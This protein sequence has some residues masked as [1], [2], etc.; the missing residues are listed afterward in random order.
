MSM[1]RRLRRQRDRAYDLACFL[2]A[3][4]AEK[5]GRLARFRAALDAQEEEVERLTKQLQGAVPT[6]YEEGMK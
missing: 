2:Q 4:L 1:V 3:E 6:T 5:T